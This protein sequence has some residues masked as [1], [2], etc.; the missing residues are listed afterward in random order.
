[1]DKKTEV[2]S[3]HIDL[4]SKNAATDLAQVDGE[5]LSQLMSRMLHNYLRREGDRSRILADWEQ[6]QRKHNKQEKSE[7]E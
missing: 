5:T 6:S 2:I 3:F 4:A 7:D 1:M